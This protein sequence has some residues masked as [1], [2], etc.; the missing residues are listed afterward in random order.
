MAA[1]EES[2]PGSLLLVGVEEGDEALLGAFRGLAVTRASSGTEALGAV[3]NRRFDALVVAHPMAGASTG[4]LLRAVR[5][6]GS[7]CQRAALVLLAPEQRRLEAEQYLGRGAN[8]VVLAREAAQRLPFEL[9]PLLRVAPRIAVRVPVR[10]T[11]G[12]GRRVMGEVVNISLTGLLARVPYTVPE[13]AAVLT[14][15]FLPGAVSAM[16]HA[17]VVRHS[18]Q[19]REP[20]PAIGLRLTW[21]GETLAAWLGDRGAATADS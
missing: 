14:E 8:R 19:G 13:G 1:R 21:M 9:P 3:A 16:A 2:V 5:A 12:G 18:H 7:L 6:P 15:L 10:L 17:V 20:Y 11:P 4:R